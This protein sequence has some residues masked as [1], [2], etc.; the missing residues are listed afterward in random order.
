MSDLQN[1][2]SNMIA[3][4]NSDSKIIDLT[5]IYSNN[6]VDKLDL[7]TSSSIT[8]DRLW[9]IFE[10]YTTHIEYCATFVDSTPCEIFSKILDNISQH[11]YK[12]RK[13][14]VELVLSEI[15]MREIVKKSIIYSDGC[16]ED[17]ERHI[18]SLISEKK[19]KIHLE[20]EAEMENKISS[21]IV[22]TLVRIKNTFENRNRRPYQYDIYRVDYSALYRDH[23]IEELYQKCKPIP[24]LF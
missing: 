12:Y 4:E 8:K 7:V 16:I 6:N 13:K 9:H 17:V 23:T 18:D 19:L 2:E 10:K 21:N 3:S 24:L 22:N 20:I 15:E 11:F 14:A 1:I 5:N